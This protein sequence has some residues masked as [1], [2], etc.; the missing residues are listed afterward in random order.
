[1]QAAKEIKILPTRHAHVEAVLF[2][3]HSHGG[4]DIVRFLHHVV[5]GHACRSPAGDKQPCQHPDRRRLASPVLTK[6]RENLTLAHRQRQAVDRPQFTEFLAKVSCLDHWKLEPVRRTKLVAVLSS[7]C[8]L[9]E[10][11]SL[12]IGRGSHQRSDLPKTP[13]PGRAILSAP[14]LWSPTHEIC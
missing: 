1:M 13:S 7:S 10:P 12:P 11:P 4:A 9:T 3:E 8:W 2:G 5:T 6:Q 14:G